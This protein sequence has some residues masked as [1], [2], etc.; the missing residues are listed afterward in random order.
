M[1][2]WVKLDKFWRKKKIFICFQRL[3]LR[4][5]SEAFPSIALR[6]CSD[7]ISIAMCYTCMYVSGNIYGVGKVKLFKVFHVV[8]FGNFL[9]VSFI[10]IQ[11]SCRWHMLFFFFHNSPKLLSCF[12]FKQNQLKFSYDR[13][14]TFLLTGIYVRDGFHENKSEWMDFL[15]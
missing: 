6:P 8:D 11:W 5:K 4:F 12:F 14:Q 10:S 2:L 1:D 13:V 3:Y 7:S 9:K 15:L